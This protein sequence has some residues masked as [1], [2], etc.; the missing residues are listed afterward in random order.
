M[1]TVVTSVQLQRRNV[2]EFMTL[3]VR[4]RRHGTPT[5]SLLPQTKIHNDQVINAA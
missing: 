2:L 4:A 1:L 3:A 5:P